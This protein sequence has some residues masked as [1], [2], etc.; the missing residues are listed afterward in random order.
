M[1]WFVAQKLKKHGLVFCVY[2]GFIPIPSSWINAALHFVRPPGTLIRL[3][4]S[5]SNVQ[6]LLSTIPP[7]KEGRQG[8]NVA[9]F[10]LFHI[11]ELF[12][13]HV[14]SNLA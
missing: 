8:V 6:T 4:V 13:Q 11:A 5:K 7:T 3:G 9:R 2:G 12:L 14:L 1:L 10:L